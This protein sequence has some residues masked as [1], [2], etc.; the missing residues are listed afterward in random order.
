MLLCESLKNAIVDEVIGGYNNDYAFPVEV[1]QK[2]DDHGIGETTLG[3][4]ILNTL[5][6]HVAQGMLEPDYALCHANYVWSAN[7]LF[8][9]HQ[10]INEK[11][12][13]V[14]FTDRCQ[15][16][17]HFETGKCEIDKSEA[18]KKK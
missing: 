5:A 2:L 11:W 10:C 12:K 16:H 18:G 8:T 6:F 3:K 4:L 13:L 1:L 15:Y 9:L 17:D 14:A 7:L